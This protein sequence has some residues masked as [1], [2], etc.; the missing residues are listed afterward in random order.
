MHQR[1]DELKKKKKWMLLPSK[2]PI[3]QT[4]SM[5]FSL[6]FRSKKKRKETA[7]SDLT[8]LDWLFN[9]ING[10]HKIVITLNKIV[11]KRARA[12]S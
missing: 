4:E 7:K 12:S 11:Q 3:I 1:R 6:L 8:W 10:A 5:R 2:V 9:L